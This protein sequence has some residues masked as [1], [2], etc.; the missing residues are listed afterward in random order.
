VH[1]LHPV[2]REMSDLDFVS[3]VWKIF[4]QRGL[5]SAKFLPYWR[6]NVSNVKS[7]YC[8]RYCRDGELTAVVSNLS[9]QPKRATVKVGGNW[10]TAR[11]LIGGGTY[12]VVGG[13]VEFDVKPFTPY[14]LA[15]E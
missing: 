15:F 14:I 11:D 9:K 12:P 6:D 7:V 13:S 2:P 4:E 3:S 8:S 5:D 1:N 10:K